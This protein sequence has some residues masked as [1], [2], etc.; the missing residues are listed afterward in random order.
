MIPL[1]LLILIVGCTSQPAETSPVLDEFTLPEGHVTIHKNGKLYLDGRYFTEYFDTDFKEVFDSTEGLYRIMS[2]RKFAVLSVLESDLEGIQSI[3]D[4]AIRELGFTQITLQSPLAKEVKEY[5]QL[6][7]CIGEGNCDFLDNIVNISHT[8]A[9][10]G[11]TS[12]FFHTVKPSKEMVTSKASIASSLFHLEEGDELRFSGR[13]YFDDTL[14]YSILDIESSFLQESPGPR[15]VIKD[16]YLGYE[17]KYGEKPLKTQTVRKVPLQTWVHI[18]VYM[19]FSSSE[20]GIVTIWQDGE[21]I[22]NTTVRTFPTHNAIIDRIE[23]GISASSTSSTMYLDDIAI[24]T[25]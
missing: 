12:L 22:L 19:Y 25:T 15:I 21:T 13:F 5:V 3:R 24:T 20:E 6:A 1:F 17:L 4:D 10:D 18:E 9:Y 16:D 14:P 23:M 7:T 2:D 11:N 8:R